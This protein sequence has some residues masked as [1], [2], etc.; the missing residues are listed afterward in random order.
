MSK[1]PLFSRRHFQM[2]FLEWK[3]MNLERSL[4][5]ITHSLGVS[6]LIWFC[7]KWWI[8]FLLGFSNMIPTTLKWCGLHYLHTGHYHVVLRHCHDWK[9]LWPHNMSFP[10]FCLC[11]MDIPSFCWKL[12]HTLWYSYLARHLLMK[13]TYPSLLDVTH[14]SEHGFSC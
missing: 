10:V 11:T 8:W 5:F 12:F 7:Q 9:S 1:W 14:H 6:L 3:C 2:H 4:N 13:K